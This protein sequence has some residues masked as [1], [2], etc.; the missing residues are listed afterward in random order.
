MIDIKWPF[1]THVDFDG[2]KL[3]ER[4]FQLIIILFAS[5]GFFG[6]YVLQQ[7][8]IAVYSVLFGAFISVLFILPPWPIYRKNPIEWQTDMNSSK[9][10]KNNSSGNSSKKDVRKLKTKKDE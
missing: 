1:S 10:N 4:L 2:Q 3:A 8:S 5:I 6:A 9:E 7:F